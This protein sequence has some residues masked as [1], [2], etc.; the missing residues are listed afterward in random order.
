MAIYDFSPA[1]AA[2]QRSKSTPYRPVIKQ[3]QLAMAKFEGGERLQA[4]F[5]WPF[6]FVTVNSP[7]R[8]EVVIHN[9]FVKHKKSIILNLG[10]L[11][12]LGL[13]QN[14]RQLLVQDRE[15]FRVIELLIEGNPLDTDDEHPIKINTKDHGIVNFGKITE[16]VIT[17]GR[18]YNFVVVQT[19]S[20]IIAG[21]IGSAENPSCLIKSQNNMR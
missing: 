3:S 7:A 20:R 16:P 21:N 1:A 2:F 12:V 14:T 11:R 8:N 10:G 19:E 17:I 6:L 5:D 18:I 4:N 9:V 15:V 13:I